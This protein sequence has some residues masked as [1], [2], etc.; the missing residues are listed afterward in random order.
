MAETTTQAADLNTETPAAPAGSPG[1]AGAAKEEAARQLVALAGGV[2]FVAAAVVVERMMSD[3][4][5]AR[6][7]RMRAARWVER[8]AMDAARLAADLSA[9]AT[10]AYRAD[11]AG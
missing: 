6:T 1:A 4:D 2:A 5:F 7:V 9:A 11:C 3:P 8:Y 10:R